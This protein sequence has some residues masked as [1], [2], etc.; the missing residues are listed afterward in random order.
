MVLD[1]ATPQKLI[2]RKAERQRARLQAREAELV[3][4]PH[5]SEPNDSQ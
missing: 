5:K 4:I 2:D 1:E 3:R